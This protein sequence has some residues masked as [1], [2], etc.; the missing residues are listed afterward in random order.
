MPN[1]PKN[2]SVAFMLEL[3]KKFIKNINRELQCHKQTKYLEN[4]FVLSYAMVIVTN[5]LLPSPR[6]K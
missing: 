1:D 3:S 5:M 4:R 2:L 6:K